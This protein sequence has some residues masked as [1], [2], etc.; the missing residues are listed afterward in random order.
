MSPAG[1]EGEA[2]KVPGR[3]SAPVCVCLSRVYPGI[4]WG[5]ALCPGLRWGVKS[6][7]RRWQLE[8]RKPSGYP[9]RVGWSPGGRR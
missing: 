6:G 9:H 5:H 2:G 4:E 8:G 7:Q 1:P 3:A